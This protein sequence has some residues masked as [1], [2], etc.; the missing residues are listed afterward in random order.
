MTTATKIK[1]DTLKTMSNQVKS[2]VREGAYGTINE[3]LKELFY[4]NQELKTYNEW[5]DEGKTV[6]KGEKALLLWGSPRRVPQADEDGE[7]RFFP[8]CHVFS[9]IQVE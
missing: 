4:N 8:I 5:K 7:Y 6:K 3:A 1:R 2:L 9:A